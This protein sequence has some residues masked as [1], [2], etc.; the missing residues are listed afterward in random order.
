MELLTTILNN[1][2]TL[3]T[4]GLTG[5]GTGIAGGINSFVQALAVQNNS[6]SIFLGVVAVFGGISLAVSLTRRI[7][8]WVESLGARG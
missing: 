7:F 6:M 4:G 3:L 5:M 2:V 8:T 1:I